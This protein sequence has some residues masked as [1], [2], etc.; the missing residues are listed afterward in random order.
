MLRKSKK[1]DKAKSVKGKKILVVG[2]GRSGIAAAKALVGMG[3]KVSVQDSESADKVDPELMEYL[4]S[5]KVKCFFGEEPKDTS[6]YDMLVLSP[7]VPTD[8][9]FV[10]EAA[11]AGAEIAGELEIAFRCGHGK[12]VAI[13]GTNGK[14]TTTTLV[15]EIFR[16]SGRKT[17]VVGNIGVA[18][19]SKAM[20]A[21][22][23]TWM[24]TETSSFQLETV[25][26]FRPVVSAI[27]N[28]TPDHMNRHHTME[29]YGR[30]KS[31]VFMN[32]EKS[33]Y[34]VINFDDKVCFALA[35]NSNATIVPFSRLEQ[36]KFGAYIHNDKIVIRD[37]DGKVT[38]FCGTEEL[39]IPGSHNLENALAAAAI[40][41]F[42]GVEPEVI[43]KTLKE[44]KGVEH[45]IE[46]C[47]EVDGVKF[48]NDSK[49]TNPDAA[50]K[51]IQAIKGDVIIIA[52]GY[53][54]GSKYDDFV[55]AFGSKVK[56]AVLLGKTAVK[57]KETAERMGFTH[58]IIVKDMEDCVNEAFR[59]AK[60]G[61][62]VLLSPACASWDMY[63][64]FE[65]RGKDFKA[66]VKKLEK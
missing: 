45:R 65:E 1:D 4:R 41:F 23:D 36:L 2:L 6:A 24:I 33:D 3:A 66:C 53:D 21:A 56:Y 37:G 58:T 22:D 14:T 47:G 12:Y 46:P 26:T 54:K 9:P 44:F 34:V 40:A 7:G 13:T 63:P 48:V 27:L 43:T 18:V 29:N 16:N 39:Q 17:E 52:G 20:E 35:R 57:I 50:I 42:A 31:N 38:E 10:K 51:A 64:N 11:E 62:T 19:I 15:G 59:L 60:P 25:S 28:L 30:V 49:G 8:L 32:Q 61:D 5:K 55:G